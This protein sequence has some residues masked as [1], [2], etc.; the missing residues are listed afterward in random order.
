[1]IRWSVELS[2]GCLEALLPSHRLI[3][4]KIATS[5]HSNI[6]GTHQD[7]C[8]SLL[9]A[10]KQ[11]I[12]RGLRKNYV[13]WWDKE[14]EIL[15]RSFTRAPVG[16]DSDRAA[17]SLLSRLGRS[18]NDGR[19]LST[20]STSRTLVARGGEQSTNLLAGLDAPFTS[21]PSWQTPSPRN[22]WRRGHTRPGTDSPPGS[23]T[24]SC[25]T[26]GRFQHL[27]VTVSPNLFRPEEFTAALRRLK[28]GKSPG[29]DSIF[30]EFIAYFTPGRLSNLGSA[31]SSVPACTNSKFER[32]GT[33]L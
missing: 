24:R 18:R 19:K 3:C 27:R 16:T 23:S 12:P 33:E 20:P 6:Q 31:T 26:Y 5:T 9:S 21:D 25:P 22:S 2:Q 13:A 14:C 10:A 29:L 7:F 30:P 1:M 32:S 8:E 4:W 28:P 11:C 15:Y 17:S